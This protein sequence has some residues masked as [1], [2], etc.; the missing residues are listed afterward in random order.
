MRISRTASCLFRSNG[1]QERIPYVKRIILCD[2]SR[3]VWPIKTAPLSTEFRGFGC[4]DNFI[5]ES[6]PDEFLYIFRFRKPPTRRIFTISWFVLSTSF[7][8]SF[9][10]LMI[11]FLVGSNNLSWTIDCLIKMLSYWM[12]TSLPWGPI[13][14]A[15]IKSSSCH[16]LLKRFKKWI[17]SRMTISAVC[18]Q[19]TVFLAASNS[20]WMS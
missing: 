11:L 7:I 13:S 9:N 2:M 5:T 20:L 12:E 14:N 19:S 10:K 18:T 8:I 1:S 17:G 6:F 16:R 3:G 15:S 4:N